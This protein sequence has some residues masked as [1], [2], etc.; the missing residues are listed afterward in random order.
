[1]TTIQCPNFNH[2]R[3]DPS[4][5]F[6]ATCGKVVNQQLSIR[7]CG[8]AVHGDARKRRTRFCVDCGEQL[9]ES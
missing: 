8:D 6:C 4:V 1:M 5:R 7:Q 9:I 2:N 3:S